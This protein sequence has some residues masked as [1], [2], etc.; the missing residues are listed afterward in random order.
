MPKCVR[1]EKYNMYAKIGIRDFIKDRYNVTLTTAQAEYL[2]SKMAV[3]SAKEDK[4][5]EDCLNA[6]TEIAVNNGFES[7][8]AFSNFIDLEVE[9]ISADEEEIL[10]YMEKNREE[11][12]ES[13][14]VTLNGYYCKDYYVFTCLSDSI[15]ERVEA[16]YFKKLEYLDMLFCEAY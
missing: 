12:P 3:Y 1:Q 11:E 13:Q 10:Y 7:R 9:R 15:Y 16:V 8:E 4:A 14:N 2:L 5:V 6:M